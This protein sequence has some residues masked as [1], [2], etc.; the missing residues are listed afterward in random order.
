MGTGPHDRPDDLEAASENPAHIHLLGHPALQSA[1]QHQTPLG[2]QHRE[3]VG[4]RGAPEVVEDDVDRL[5]DASP[6]PGGAGVDPGVHPEC[7]GSVKLA[8][9]PGGPNHRAS[10]PLGQLNGGRA[11]TASNRVHEDPITG[12]RTA[13]HHQRI[14]RRQ[15]RLRHRSRLFVGQG[16][17]HGNKLSLVG[18]HELG[19]SAPTDQAHDSVAGLDQGDTRPHRFNDPSILETRNVRRPTRRCGVPTLPLN[20]VGPIESNS[21]NP[22]QDM[23]RGHRRGRSFRQRNY[24]RPAG[25]GVQNGSHRVKLNAMHPL[26]PLLLCCLVA[27]CRGDSSP[28][29]PPTASGLGLAD[30]GT[31]SFPGLVTSP[32]GDNARIFV[33]EKTGAIKIVKQGITLA[34]PFLDVRA[35]ISTGGEQGLLGLAFHPG[36]ATNGLSVVNY[37]DPASEQIVLSVDQPFANHNGGMVA[38]GPDGQLY[39]GMG[40]GGSGGDAQGNGQKQSTLLG[41]MVR[42]SVSAAGQV[43]VPSDNPFVGQPGTRLEIESLGLRNPWRFSF[44]RPTGDLYIGDV[45]QNAIEEIDALSLSASRGANFGWNIMEGKSCFGSSSCNQQCLV[46]P[47]LDYTHANGAG[48]VTGGYVYRGTAISGLAGTYFYADYCRGWVR[49]FRLV[50]GSATDEREWG[51]LAPNG[52]ITSFGQDVSGELYLMTAAGRVARIV[53]KP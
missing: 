42:L 32:P 25:P 28:P 43:T 53:T 33:V 45:G 20:E 23:T 35:K 4:E 30:V 18:R 31:F 10:D 52:Q 39:I 26:L 47:V 15:K 3:I 38:F 36:Y 27:A 2:C 22:D 16:R 48:S 50:N 29:P 9:G 51:D 17:G 44:D 24:F 12:S 1:E 7:P 40:D 46:L 5:A 41:K 14:V 34:T 49:S 11:D 19:V 6:K 13:P 37:T 21:P 8:G